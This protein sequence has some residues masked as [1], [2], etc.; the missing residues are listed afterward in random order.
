MSLLD[1]F[2][3]GLADPQEHPAAW[4]AD[5]AECQSEIFL[6]DRAIID[7]GGNYYCDH[8]CYIEATGARYV[9]AGLED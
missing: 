4:I 5:C 7:D 6:G 8:R 9:E 3:V 2:A 1:R